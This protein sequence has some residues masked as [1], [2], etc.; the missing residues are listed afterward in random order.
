MPEIKYISSLLCK[1]QSLFTYQ[2]VYKTVHSLLH[3]PSYSCGV[4][5]YT[6]C[7]HVCRHLQHKGSVISVDSG[8]TLC[9]KLQNRMII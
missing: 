9:L 2:G 8:N 6:L 5:E 7:A 4:G 3:S 1:V